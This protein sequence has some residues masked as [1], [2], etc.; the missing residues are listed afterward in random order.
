MIRYIKHKNINKT[1]WD[2]CIDNSYN[3]L[4]Y[5]YSWYLDIVSPKWDALVND[6]YVSVMPLTYRKKYGISYLFQPL[7]C[8]QLGVFST[9]NKEAFCVDDFIDAIPKKFKIIEIAVNS[10]NLITEL[11]GERI[12]TVGVNF[13]LS[14]NKPY[15]ILFTHYSKKHIKNINKISPAELIIETGNNLLND[16]FRYK[17]E[18]I[19]IQKIKFS[20]KDKVSY[21]KFLNDF[22][23]KNKLKIYIAKNKEKVVLGGICL[24]FIENRVISISF[25]S[26]AGR[27]ISIGYYLFNMF[28]KEYAG[29]DIIYDF[30]GSNIK[31]IAYRN[32]GF[33]SIK[34]FYKQVKITRLPKMLRYLKVI[35]DL[36]SLK[37]GR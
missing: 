28:I 22:N 29:H 16:F 18:S 8:Q 34:S 24:F 9:I 31:N 11:P 21:Y 33:G 12:V 36:V 37:T 5:A 35:W 14:L 10:K 23:V 17:I 4:F 32:E 6:D 19:S 13:E 1:K 27:K 2:Y 26:D 15:D 25:S 7:L 30:M 20:K 3:K